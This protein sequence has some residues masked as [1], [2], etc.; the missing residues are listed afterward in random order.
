MS[1]GLGDEGLAPGDAIVI[2]TSSA[3]HHNAVADYDLPLAPRMLNPESVDGAVTALFSRSVTENFRLRWNALQERF[4]DNPKQAVREG[5]ELVAKVS[6]SLAQTFGEQGAK[7]ERQVGRASDS[8]TEELRL[9]LRRYHS[10]FERL[11]AL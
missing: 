10:L 7:F 9:A 6:E 4:V 5:A 3:G 11:L 2:A 8:S 1:G